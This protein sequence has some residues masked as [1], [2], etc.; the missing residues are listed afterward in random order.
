MVTSVCVCVC[1]CVCVC[2]GGGDVQLFLQILEKA[3]SCAYPFIGISPDRKSTVVFCQ[4][5]RV[6]QYFIR[7]Y[8]QNTGRQTWANIDLDK[9]GLQYQQSD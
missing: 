2:R 7:Y 1:A 4:M 8:N 5:G 3:N 6:H 9:N